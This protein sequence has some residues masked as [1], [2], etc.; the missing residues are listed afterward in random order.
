MSWLHQLFRRAKAEAELNEE[1]R[2]Y[3]DQETQL[4]IDRGAS[5]SEARQAARRDF[6]SLAL[7]KETTRERW[8]WTLIENFVRDLHYAAR[9]LRRSPLFA[10]TAIVSLALGIGANTAIFS[11]MDLVMLRMLPV[12]EPHRLVQVQK[13]HGDSTR[14][15]LSYPM[16][17]ELRRDLRNFDGLLAHSGIDQHEV[18]IDGRQETVKAELVS[19]NYHQVLGVSAQLGRTFSGETAG[20]VAVI[21]D[22]YWRRRFGSDPSAIGRTFQLNKAVFTI[23]GVMPADFFGTVAGIVADITIPM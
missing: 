17:D 8:G 14:G 15:N 5:P 3:L 12:R 22:G 21:S 2:F 16:F 19:D 20:P 13:L 1:I 7:V 4:R 6:G 11:L 10:S 23:A 18:I 9:L